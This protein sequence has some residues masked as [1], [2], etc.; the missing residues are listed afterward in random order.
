MTYR[1]RLYYFIVIII[2][3]LIAAPLV[4]LYATGWRFNFQTMQIQKV[5]GLIIK[6]EPHGALVNLNGKSLTKKTPLTANNLRPD[7]YTILVS[8]EGYYNWTRKVEIEPGESW[9]FDSIYLLKNSPPLQNL[10][11]NNISFATFSPTGGKIAALQNQHIFIIDTPTA[12]VQHDLRQNQRGFTL[13]WSPDESYITV[14][15]DD[16]SC[17][18]LNMNEPEKII[19]LTKEYDL[20]ITNCKWSP[21]DNSVLY[22]TT[23]NGL[24]RL[25]IFQHTKTLITDKTDIWPANDDLFIFPE[26]SQLNFAKSDFKLINQIN[27]PE[28]NNLQFYNC[29]E[30]Y[31]CIVNTLQK[32][33][34]I[35]NVKNNNYNEFS[36]EVTGISFIKN[37]EKIIVYNEHEIW[38][39]NLANGEKKFVTRTSDTINSASW[40]KSQNY[41]IYGQN[42]SGLTILEETEFSQNIYEL[43]ATDINHLAASNTGD[44]A[45]I[46]TAGQLKIIPF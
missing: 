16:G 15:N 7:E 20:A 22:V 8:K 29:A 40:L 13:E 19:D 35:Y 14:K 2:V 5:G 18:A 23:P 27:L 43:A 36:A 10:D 12:T 45:M 34:Y 30:N 32:K 28:I 25:N 21:V 6:T 41:I 11:L 46:I 3:F 38:T 17:L 26:A 42:N 24:Y 31:V 44:Y 39:L 33:M 1:Q 37:R 4:I 9:R